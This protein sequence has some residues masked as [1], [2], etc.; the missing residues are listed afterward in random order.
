MERFAWPEVAGW[1]FLA[2]DAW[3]YA[4]DCQQC[5]SEMAVAFNAASPWRWELRDSAAFGDYLRCLPHP[6]R[7]I[8]LHDT[9]EFALR[10]PPSVPLGFQEPP[11]KFVATLELDPSDAALRP[12]LDTRFL[13]LLEKLNVYRLHAFECITS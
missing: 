9:D 10:P 4:F 7:R 12:E 11:P 5:L 1:L 3:G 6:G 8:R 13:L 2:P